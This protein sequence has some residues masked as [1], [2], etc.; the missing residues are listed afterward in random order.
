MRRRVIR[1]GEHI[2]QTKGKQGHAKSRKNSAG[3]AEVSGADYIV[4]VR[5]ALTVV[6]FEVSISLFVARR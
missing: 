5:R 3:L 6:R 1:L 4:A 2:A